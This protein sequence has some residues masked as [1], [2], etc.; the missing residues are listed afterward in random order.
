MSVEYKHPQ[1]EK[2]IRTDTNLLTLAQ[3]KA[4][5]KVGFRMTWAHNPQQ[6]PSMGDNK[7]WEK[8][9]K[10]AL[11][12]IFPGYSYGYE[13]TCNQDDVIAFLIK[14]KISFVASAHYGQESIF[15]DSQ[16]DRLVT[17]VNFGEIFT[18]HGV[19]P[20]DLKYYKDRKPFT[21]TTGTMFRK[22]NKV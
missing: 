19:H 17:A 14:N 9:E 20:D 15:F 1:D 21:V 10:G 11:D 8:H 22:K 3:E 12:E 16:T 13:V 5:K 18:M 4:L 7:E 6:V 2:P